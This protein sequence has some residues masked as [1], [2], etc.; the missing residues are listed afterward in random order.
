MLSKG[1]NV[2]YDYSILFMDMLDVFHAFRE[3]MENDFTS[4]NVIILPTLLTTQLIFG[5]RIVTLSFS[6]FGL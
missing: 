3:V 6:T 2:I 5:D 1:V 4:F